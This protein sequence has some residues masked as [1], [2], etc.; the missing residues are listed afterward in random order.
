MLRGDGSRYIIRHHPGNY[1]VVCA[2]RPVLAVEN[3]AQRLVS[4][5]ALTEETLGGVLKTLDGLIADR[6]QPA[7]IRIETL[8]GAPIL[9]S[10]AASA[11][12]S[13]GF[14]REDQGMVRYREF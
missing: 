5:A 1:L 14:S 6:T 7:A 2:G 13:L 12:S 8:D 10:R 4:L 9:G 3:R 11:L